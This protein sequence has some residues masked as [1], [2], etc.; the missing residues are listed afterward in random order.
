MIKPLSIFSSKGEDG[1]VS[2]KSNPLPLH[3]SSHLN[4]DESRDGW[5]FPPHHPLRYHEVFHPGVEANLIISGASSAMHAINSRYLRADHLEVW[6]LL[7][8]ETGPSFKW[9]A[10]RLRL[11]ELWLRM[12]R[13]GFMQRRPPGGRKSYPA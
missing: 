1:N 2:W 3:H 7:Q 6:N 8:N 11:T 9:C 10:L 13:R 5:E 12:W 4:P